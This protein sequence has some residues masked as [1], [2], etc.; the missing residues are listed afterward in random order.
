MV[1]VVVEVGLVHTVQVKMAAPAA[2]VMVQ[3]ADKVFQ[4][5]GI[6]AVAQEMVVVVA[7]AAR[8]QTQVWQMVQ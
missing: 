3:Q 8:D 1:A 7:P 2:E 5:K 6:K 4:D